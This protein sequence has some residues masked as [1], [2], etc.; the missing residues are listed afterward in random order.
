[1]TRLIFLCLLSLSSFAGSLQDPYQLVLDWKACRLETTLSPD[2]KETQRLMTILHAN[3]ELLQDNP[4]Q[5]G[6]K[7][8][9]VQNE[10]VQYQSKDKPDEEKINQLQEELSGL[11]STVGWL[12][13][14]K[15]C[16][17]F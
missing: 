11:L 17:I 3:V 5:M 6:M 12:E 16:S 13:S 7:I 9:S 4:Q 14:P 8:M 2:C 1:M 10:I 15:Q